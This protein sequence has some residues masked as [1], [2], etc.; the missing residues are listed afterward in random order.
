MSGCVSK[1][2]RKRGKRGGRE[3][4]KRGRREGRGEGG[5]EGRGEGGRER[6][7]GGWEGGMGK[8]YR[9]VR[10]L[11]QYTVYMYACIN[12]PNNHHQ[13]SYSLLNDSGHG[14]CESVNW[15]SVGSD[16]GDNSEKNTK[17]QFHRRSI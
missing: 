5:R 9:T 3:R 6:G 10:E 15:V 1:G 17:R 14:A 4:E 13:Y 2:G 8:L 16:S 12:V 7:E 11:T